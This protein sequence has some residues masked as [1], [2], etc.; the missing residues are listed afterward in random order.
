MKSFGSIAKAI[1]LVSALM[2]LGPKIAAAE[3]RRAELYALIGYRDFEALDA[4]IVRT[5]I[6]QGIAQK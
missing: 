2:L 5:L 4:S 1:S 3:E 6:P